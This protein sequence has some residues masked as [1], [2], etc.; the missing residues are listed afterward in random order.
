MKPNLCDELIDHLHIDQRLLHYFLY[1]NDETSLNVFRH[2]DLT[3]LSLAQYLA[4][5]EAL[6]HSVPALCFRLG[7]VLDGIDGVFNV[8]IINAFMFVRFFFLACLLLLDLNQINSSLFLLFL[9]QQPDETA[10]ILHQE[11][12]I[13]VSQR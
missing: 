4:E 3:K 8:E 1:G 7:P 9:V 11:T 6:D 13:A 10:A 5:L 2:V 12:V